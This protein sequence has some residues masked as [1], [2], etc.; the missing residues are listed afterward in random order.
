VLDEES[1][2]DLHPLRARPCRGAAHT[3]GCCGLRS[4][5]VGLLDLRNRAES[6]AASDRFP[7]GDE[8]LR[9]AGVDGVGERPGQA[10][11]WALLAAYL[12]KRS[13]LVQA[14]V[15]GLCVGLFV[16]AVAEADQR[17]T[18]IESTVL[19]V[20]AGGIVAG[21]LFYL[22]LRAQVRHGWAPGSPPP[23]WVN[24]VY[25]AVWMLSLLAALR[26]LLGAG[27]LKVA[28]LAIVPIV[29][30]APPAIVGARALLGRSPGRGA[31][32][33]PTTS[34]PTSSPPTSSP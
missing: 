9:R 11:I 2:E 32:P 34:P 4:R 26:A 24:L 14:L 3:I 8:G 16:A 23:G 19:L 6:G 7:K 28:V 21:T 17:D 30:L 20:L 13:P 33:S 27:G 22:G 15:V 25:V 12:T 18:A 1:G 31:D 10:M 5:D 29:L